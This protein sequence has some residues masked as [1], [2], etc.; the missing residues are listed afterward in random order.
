MRAETCSALGLAGLRA[1]GGGLAMSGATGG[2]PNVTGARLYPDYGG[3][4]LWLPNRRVEWEEIRVSPLLRFRLEAWVNEALHNTGSVITD[5]AFD[6]EGYELARLL[7][8]ELNWSVVY[9]G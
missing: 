8:D 1:R 7:S 4:P 5:E 6:A 9:E 2:G 3:S